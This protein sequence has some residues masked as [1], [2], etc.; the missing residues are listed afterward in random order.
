MRTV[1]LVLLSLACG[2]VVYWFLNSATCG[3]AI[4]EVTLPDGVS[5][6][7][8]PGSRIL[9]TNNLTI[10]GDPKPVELQKIIIEASRFP[11]SSTNIDRIHV[12]PRLALAAEVQ[13]GDQ[14]VYLRRAEDKWVIHGYS[15]LKGG[16]PS[17]RVTI[18]MEYTD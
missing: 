15:Y 3:P 9:A 12:F 16:S 17:R 18:Q 7:L 5:E 6:I 8:P 4:Q 2:V 14:W 11:F 10:V 1:I 13:V